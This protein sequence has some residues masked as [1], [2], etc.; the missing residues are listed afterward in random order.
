LHAAIDEIMPCSDGK[1]V[2]TLLQGFHFSIPLREEL[3]YPGQ[4]LL[5]VLLCIHC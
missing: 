1:S 2:Q 3:R 5:L 4:I